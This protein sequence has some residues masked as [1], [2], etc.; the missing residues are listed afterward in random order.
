[1]PVAASERHA[2]QGEE[3]M[4]TRRRRARG[5]AD[6]HVGSDLGWPALAAGSP[7]TR[8]L[9]YR[10]RGGWVGLQKLSATF[11]LAP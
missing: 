1:M 8:V 2:I 9:R 5:Q 7:V 3:K 6:A 11:R 4:A 10:R